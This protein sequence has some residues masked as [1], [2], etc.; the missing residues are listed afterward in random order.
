MSVEIVD[1]EK[2]GKKSMKVTLK[3]F[4]EDNHNLFTTMGV[5]GGLAALFTRL[6]NAEYL[7]F[8]AFA[9]LL[10][11]DWELWRAFPKSEEAT[12]T[13]TIFEYFSQMFMFLIG[14]Y[15]CIAY[16]TYILPLLP[17]ILASVLAAISILLFKRFELYKYVRKI[18]PEGK[19]YSSLIRSIIAGGIIIAIFL[20]AILITRYIIPLVMPS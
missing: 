7:S 16:M 8:I 9:M 1:S 19:R 3:Q 4:I 18:A 2:S 14:A 13:I 15:I 5:F 12:L 20:V 17:T 10:L 6:E 11:L